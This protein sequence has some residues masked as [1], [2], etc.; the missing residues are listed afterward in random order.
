MRGEETTLQPGSS[1]EKLVSSR[2]K[3]V[4][5]T[6]QTRKAQPGALGE[7]RT[8]S[9]HVPGERAYPQSPGHANLLARLRLLCEER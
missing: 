2:L 1:G 3:Q 7:I 5:D 9:S 8:G 6:V 4:G